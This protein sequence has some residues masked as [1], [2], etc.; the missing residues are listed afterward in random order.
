[1]ISYYFQGFA[2]GAAMILPLGP[3]N[4]F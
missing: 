4:A 1:M 3:Q 2:L